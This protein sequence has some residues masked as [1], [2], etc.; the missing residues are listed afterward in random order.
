MASS[1]MLD[2]VLLKKCAFC[3]L[4]TVARSKETV[5]L[6]LAVAFV[7]AFHLGTDK[8]NLERNYLVF[9]LPSP[10]LSVP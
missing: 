5:M 6:L 4:S 7:L 3:Q 2:L 1:L 9:L 8:R 10:C